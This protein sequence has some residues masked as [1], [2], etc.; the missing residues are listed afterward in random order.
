MEFQLVFEKT[1]KITVL[2]YHVELADPGITVDED[3]GPALGVGDS[4]AVA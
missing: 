1:V 4:L 2:F 3:V